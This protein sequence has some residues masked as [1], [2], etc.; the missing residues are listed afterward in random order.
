VA[1]YVGPPAMRACQLGPDT[2]TIGCVGVAP[3]RQERGVGTA[4]AAC[5]SEIL[6]DSG[7]RTCHISWTAR[8]S[9]YTHAGTSHGAGTA[10][11]TAPY[12]E[13]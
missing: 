13:H 1:G 8:E 2:G 9:F 3:H 7:T 4:M 12:P 6:R 10:C 5:A 11:S